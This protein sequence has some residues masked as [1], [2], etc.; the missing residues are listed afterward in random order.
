MGVTQ[1]YNLHIWSRSN[2]LPSILVAARHWEKKPGTGN[3]RTTMLGEYHSLDSPCTT[4]RNARGV[5][6]QILPKLEQLQLVSPV[7]PAAWP[8]TPPLLPLTMEHHWLLPCAGSNLVRKGMVRHPA[9]HGD[10]PA[11]PALPW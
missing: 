4:G 10:I 8:H 11:H 7:P 6:E 9:L 3:G 5:W 2:L 1:C